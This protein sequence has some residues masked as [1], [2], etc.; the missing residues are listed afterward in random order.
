M[1]IVIISEI[2]ACRP[3]CIFGIFFFKLVFPAT[4]FHSTS[5]FKKIRY[6]SVFVPSS[7]IIFQKCPKQCI[8]KIT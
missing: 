2:H 7:E 4:P 6:E 8:F 3:S 1:P 5:F